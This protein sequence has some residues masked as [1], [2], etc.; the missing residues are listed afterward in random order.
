MLFP[1]V[2]L[3]FFHGFHSC[4]DLVNG[5]WTQLQS[6]AWL[7]L[8]L[9]L[10][11]SLQLQKLPRGN[12]K[13]KRP[14]IL[15]YLGHSFI[16]G[17]FL[18]QNKIFVR[19]LQIPSFVQPVILLDFFFFLQIKPKPT[20]RSYGSCRHLEKG[21]AIISKEQLANQSLNRGSK[22]HPS[23]LMQSL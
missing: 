18:T 14:N 20:I 3:T 8:T 21:K 11:E 10:R 7:I 15:V 17:C 23:S 22:F 6:S 4:Y 13:A 16:Q 2:W 12:F 19:L 9:F 5:F 1:S